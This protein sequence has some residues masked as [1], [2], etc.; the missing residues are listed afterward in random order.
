VVWAFPISETL[1][2]RSALPIQ[3]P[4]K[5][6]TPAKCCFFLWL[7]AHKRCSTSDRLAQRGLPHPEKCPLCDQ[8]NES[9]DHLLIACVLSRQFR[10]YILKQ[11]VLRSLAPQP[12]NTS[13]DDWWE[14]ASAATI[15]LTQKGLNSL[16]VLGAWIIW[17]HRNSCI[18]D[19]ANTNI[20]G[21][22]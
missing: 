1:A 22:C 16:I 12:T 19:G 4:G 10:Y 6:W 2:V 17:N 14:K 3:V 21:Q 15:G 7:V 5:T 8:A 13:F 18:F 9:I 11:V 20:A